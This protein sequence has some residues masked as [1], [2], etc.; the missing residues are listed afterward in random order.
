MKNSFGKEAKILFSKNLMNIAII[1]VFIFLFLDKKWE[2]ES[3]FLIIIGTIV[4]VALAILE[5]HKL[6]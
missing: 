4:A 5:V 2:P 1:I 6:W 3:V